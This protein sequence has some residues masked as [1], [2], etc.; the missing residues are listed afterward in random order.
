MHIRSEDDKGNPVVRV[1]LG[2]SRKQVTLDADDYQKLIDRGISTNWFLNRNSSN[3]AY[4]RVHAPRLGDTKNTESVQRLIMNP[5]PSECVRII[6]GDTL[7]LRRSNLKIVKR[8]DHLAE[9]SLA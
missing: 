8:G 7:N 6:D 1:I 3:R 4:V 2:K 5:G 9:L